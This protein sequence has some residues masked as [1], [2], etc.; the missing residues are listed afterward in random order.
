[1][2]AAAAGPAVELRPAVPADDRFLYELYADTR[3]TELA[4]L[5][6]DAAA[7][8]AFLRMQFAARNRAYATAH[9][10]AAHDVVLVDG[11]AAGALWVD[12]A[13]EEI[14]LVDIALLERHRGHGVGRRLLESLIA[15]AR[16]RGRAVRLS[17]VRDN[18]ARRLYERLGF[19]L[20]TEDDVYLA[21]VFD[22]AA[23]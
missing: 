12:R 21:L 1:L 5:P 15:E 9:P 2:S 7:M 8:E 11:D 17:V 23:S 20:V 10:D 3:A 16:E 19:R 13:G 14:A 4:G 22:P 6:W 18:P